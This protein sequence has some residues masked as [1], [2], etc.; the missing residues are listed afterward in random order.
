MAYPEFSRSRTNSKS[1]RPPAIDNY[2]W[3]AR[4]KISRA[5]LLLLLPVLP[6]PIKIRR[7]TQG[8]SACTLL[9]RRFPTQT[10]L[11][12]MTISKSKRRWLIGIGVV[13]ALGLVAVIVAGSILAHRFDPYI[14]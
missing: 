1:K 4:G 13:I 14:R 2:N 9:R 7:L 11:N 5:A 12:R 6:K 3:A 8:T 10:D